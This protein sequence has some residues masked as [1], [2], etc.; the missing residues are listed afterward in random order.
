MKHQHHQGMLQ[1]TF[2][3]KQQEQTEV[4]DFFFKSSSFYS[5]KVPNATLLFKAKH[6]VQIR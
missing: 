1:H 4:T 5:D 3:D 2:I 6:G